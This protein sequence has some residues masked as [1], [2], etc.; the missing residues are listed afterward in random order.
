[1][2]KKYLFLFFLTLMFVG[3]LFLAINAKHGDMYNNLDWGYGAHKLG[4]FHFYEWPKEAWPHSR[5]NQPPGSIYLHLAS[6]SFYKSIESM[7]KWSNDKIPV[8]PSKLVWWWSDH[9]ELIAI[10]LPS[11]FADFVI[12]WVVYRLS[13]KWLAG[14]YLLNPPLWYDSSFWG[15]TD[16]VVAALSM[17]SLYFLSKKQ[18]ARS[19]GV[20][21]LSLIT[22]A[23]WAPVVLLYGVYFLLKH[24]NKSWN[25]L[26][27]PLVAV[28]ISLPFGVNLFDLYLNRILPGETAF[29]SVGA[30]NFQHL[31]WG[32][33]SNPPQAGMLAV[34]L[35]GILVFMAIRGLIKKPDFWTFWK[36]SI[37]LLWGT[38]LFNV[39]MHERYLYPVFPML[40]V[41]LFVKKSKV[42][43]MVYAILSGVF[44]F[45][46]YYKWWAPGNLWLQSLYTDFN[47]NM[48]SM[49]SLL[50]FTILTVSVYEKN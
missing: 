40:T 16:S 13:N 48:V 46:L 37:L 9:G 12:A 28:L 47:I 15:Q 31:L 4:L 8:F 30:F 22:K 39:R 32:Q 1:M 7:I 19:A 49:V 10:K 36:W 5:P 27:M 50:L 33:F 20:M 45:N 43:N 24:F 25:L 6:V 35:V 3:R 44:L 38:F 21:G 18:L 14:L 34:V 17:L 2:I 41:F 23:S 11:I 42:L 26:F 29:A